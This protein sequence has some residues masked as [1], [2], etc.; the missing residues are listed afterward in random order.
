MKKFN[1]TCLAFLLLHVQ[2]AA[3]HPQ[4]SPSQENYR[5]CINGYSSCDLSQLRAPERAR[6]QE[7]A[8]QRNYSRCLHGYSSSDSSQLAGAEKPIVQQA[9]HQRNYSS[10]LRGYSSCDP[11]KLEQTEIASVAKA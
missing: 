3:T 7:V 11:S 9:A 1:I 10:C 2:T 4:Q 8:H 6:V 5:N